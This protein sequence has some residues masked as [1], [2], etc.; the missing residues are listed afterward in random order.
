MTG[1][2]RLIAKTSAALSTKRRS[3]RN[4]TMEDFMGD[5]PPF[6]PLRSPQRRPQAPHPK[7]KF[8]GV[9]QCPE[10]RGRR[11]ITETMNR[12]ENV[13]IATSKP[14]V[15]ST[16]AG[17]DHTGESRSRVVGVLF[18][19]G[20]QERESNRGNPSRARCE[21]RETGRGS[22]PEAANPSSAGCGDQFSSRLR[23]GRGG[24]TN[25]E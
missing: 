1:R 7:S 11:S 21:G 22:L 6:S 12:K 15:S 10:K 8:L 20:R 23:R 25:R 19:C 17:T 16:A 24:A 4:Q 5:Q 3:L 9:S 13:E 2:P 18:A 14:P